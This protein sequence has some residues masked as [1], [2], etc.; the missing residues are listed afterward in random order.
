[1]TRTFYMSALGWKTGEN[2]VREKESNGKINKKPKAAGSERIHW[3]IV[4]FWE[5]L[6]AKTMARFKHDSQTKVL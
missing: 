6:Q 1:M 4:A 3:R 5:F 2:T